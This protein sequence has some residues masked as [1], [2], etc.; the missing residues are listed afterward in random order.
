MAA[1]GGRII[2]GLCEVKSHGIDLL[3]I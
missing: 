1:L 3:N 2:G